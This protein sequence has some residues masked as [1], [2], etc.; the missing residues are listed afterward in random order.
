MYLYRCSDCNY[1]TELT[2]HRKTCPK[3]KSKEFKERTHYKCLETGKM[4]LYK[5]ET[6]PYVSVRLG[7]SE[8]KTVDHLG[9]RNYERDMKSGEFYEK[10]KKMGMEPKKKAKPTPWRTKEKIDTSLARMTESQK[11]KY[12]M[13]GQRP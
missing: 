3:C 8:L 7:D 5:K 1:Q 11:E 12:I 10:A 2:K 4:V 6:S 13:T 9:R